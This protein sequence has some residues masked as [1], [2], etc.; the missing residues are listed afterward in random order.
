M[1][2][3][4]TGAQSLLVSSADRQFF[5]REVKYII[6]GVICLLA[7]ALFLVGCTDQDNTEVPPSDSAGEPAQTSTAIPA[8]AT[9]IIPTFTNIPVSPTALI[10]TS[11]GVPATPTALIPTSTVTPARTHLVSI[12]E[13]YELQVDNEPAFNSVYLDQFVQLSGR[14]TKISDDRAVEVWNEAGD[15]KVLCRVPQAN[16][17]TLVP[18]RPGMDVTVLGKVAVE[19]YLLSGIT[20]AIQD[21]YVLH[22]SIPPTPTNTPTMTPTSTHTMTPTPI[23]TNTPTITST[24][25]P[26]T[27]TPTPTLSPTITLTPV[28]TSYQVGNTDGDGVYL[29]ESAGGDTRIKAWPDGTLMMVVGP[30]ESIGDRLWR[31]VQD[32][33]GNRGYVPVEYLVKHVP[34]TATPTTPRPTKTATSQSRTPQ[35][36]EATRRYFVTLFDSLEPLGISMAGISQLSQEVSTNPQLLV[37][38]QWRLEYVIYLAGLQ[39]ASREIINMN[40]PSDALASKIHSNVVAAA[41]LYEES[42]DLV[43]KGLDDFDVDTLARG[44]QKIVQ[45]NERLEQA[46]ELMTTCG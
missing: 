8:T 36:T 38:E 33:D 41:R 5:L 22:Y 26:A 17:E 30:D 15:K 11:T 10:S 39:A 28:S 40:P 18:V 44:G 20:I 13:L 43:A 4:Q 37:D 19:R 9:E 29:R 16:I 2:C 25:L 6:P 42:V 3:Q 21:C 14:V 7:C 45:G 24:P 46:S 27:P 32:P 23:P 35:C 1:F 12:G 31:P 34:P